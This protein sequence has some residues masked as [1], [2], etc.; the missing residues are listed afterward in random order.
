[1][2]DESTGAVKTTGV[3]DS[4]VRIEL[5]L[6]QKIADLLE[7]WRATQRPVSSWQGAIRELLAIGAPAKARPAQA[8]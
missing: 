3:V 5:R 4:P 6:A 1:L 2:L 7:H 8:R